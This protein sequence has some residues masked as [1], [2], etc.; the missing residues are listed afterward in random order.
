MTALCIFSLITERNPLLMRE[1]VK[2][3]IRTGQRSPSTLI[4]EDSLV[5]FLSAPHQRSLTLDT[6]SNTDD[7]LKCKFDQVWD[8]PLCLN[9]SSEND[10]MGIEDEMCLEKL[11]QN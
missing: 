6:G 4:P 9:I 7:F 2:G 3:R 10:S 5:A 8:C 11:S 1:E